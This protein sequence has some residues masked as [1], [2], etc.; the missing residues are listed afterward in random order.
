[1]TSTS[2]GDRDHSSALLGVRHTQV[3]T[4]RGSFWKGEVA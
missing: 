1:V 3:S 4:F 2:E